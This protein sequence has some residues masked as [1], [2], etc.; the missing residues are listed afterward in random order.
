LS[1]LFGKQ[2]SKP[3]IDPARGDAEAQRLRQAAGVRDWRSVDAALSA[4]REVL[5]REFLA[6]AVAMNCED[7]SWVDAW[8]RE[9][10]ESQSARLM[11]GASAV[12]LAWKVRS[13]LAPQYVSSDQ[14]K[15]FH[16][17]LNHAQEQLN[18][19][20]TMDPDDSAPWVALLWCGVGLEIPIDDARARWDNAM[21][22]NPQTEL[23]ALAFTTHLGPRW[24][25]ESDLMWTFIR[26]L[27]GH[28]PEGSP[29]WSLVPHG[30]MEQW[31]SERMRGGSAV[32]PS[33]YWEQ[34]EVQRDIKDAHAKY[35][36]SPAKRRSYLEPQFRELFAG[37]F[38]LMGARDLLRKELE[39][40]GPGIQGLPWG[41]LGSALVAYQ[42]A[43]EAAGLK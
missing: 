38:Y 1:P 3:F 41:Y 37:C 14:M 42:S 35:L 13:G 8:V 36:G 15:G 43:R 5:R 12:Q 31:V 34:A 4:T 19:A 11:W 21:R 27:V 22:R 20:A 18:A 7:L 30:H 2:A 32:H 16:D 10:P 23:S 40:I 26:E 25:G 17:W 29:R 24:N 28:E 9:Q 33:R 6:D 39:Q